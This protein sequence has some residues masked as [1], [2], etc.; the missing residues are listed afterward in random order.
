MKKTLSILGTVLLVAVCAALA[1]EFVGR[2][3]LRR[4][5]PRA[6]YF[7]NVILTTHEGKKVRFYDDLMHGKVVVV[8][9]M[10]T[11]CEGGCLP[12]TGNLVKV[13]KLLG[14]R[15]GRDI[16]FYSITLDPERDTPADLK[17]YAEMHEVGPG[18][19]F[20]TGSKADCELLR[21]RLGFVDTDPLLDA[22]KVEHAGIVLYG[23][24]SLDRWAACPAL[25]EPS[26]IVHY[27]SWVEHPK[28]EMP[29]GEA[30]PKEFAW[31]T[32][33]EQK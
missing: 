18:W 26:E 9:F 4:E 22:K 2:D 28:G 11:R 15:V 21:K 5:G 33:P 14:D 8:T 13:Q 29:K 24:E 16:H 23:N 1:W 7:P 30:R 6:G 20:L 25:S 31:S 19:T 32:K 27:I 3:L 12:T 10:Y 17:E